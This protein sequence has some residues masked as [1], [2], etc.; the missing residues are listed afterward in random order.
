MMGVMWLLID[1]LLLR[2]VEQA[3]IVRWGLVRN[4]GGN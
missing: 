3:T 1:R 2:P 4:Q